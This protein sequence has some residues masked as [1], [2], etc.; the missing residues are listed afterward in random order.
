MCDKICETCQFWDRPEVPID[1]S[2]GRECHRFP[3]NVPVI[4][5]VNEFGMEVH[6]RTIGRDSTCMTYPRTYSDEW[7]GEWR[8]RE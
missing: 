5:Y 6:L 8:E 4:E 1:E 7:C 3:P 2:G